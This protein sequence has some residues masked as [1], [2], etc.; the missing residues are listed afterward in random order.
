MSDC[1]A[2]ILIPTYRR[3]ESLRKQVE[4]LKHFIDLSKIKII[5]LDGSDEEASAN[6]QICSDIS[7]LEYRHYGSRIDVWQRLM[8][9][10][11]SVTTEIVSILADDDFLNPEGYYES[12]NFL[13]KNENY[14][15][16]AG[17]YG[18]YE[19]INNQPILIR[20][21]YETP[22]WDQ[23][24]PLERLRAMLMTITTNILFYGVHRSSVLKIAASE[25]L[26][27]K[28][29]ID[30]RSQDLYLA[31]IS[32]L[33]GKV[34]RTHSF[35]YGRNSAPN[36]GGYHTRSMGVFES[37][38]PESSI[39]KFIF[40]P[41]FSDRHYA[42]KRTIMKYISYEDEGITFEQASDFLDESFAQHYTN[43]FRHELM[44]AQGIKKFQKSISQIVN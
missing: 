16:A 18:L 29:A 22:S 38:P 8:V 11:H 43:C 5:V 6:K 24:S 40:H 9:G 21:T 42:L 44:H 3:V 4:L 31:C 32:C 33:M 12:I 25:A 28:C 13:M 15:V 27:N 35:Y 19:W 30:Q 41:N 1:I 7:G 20:D 36:V 26:D 39:I 23:D 14:S 17:K 10:I 37:M 2:T 34:K